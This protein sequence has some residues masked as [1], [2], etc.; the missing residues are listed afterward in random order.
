MVVGY[1]IYVAI[2]IGVC[3]LFQEQFVVRMRK[4]LLRCFPHTKTSAAA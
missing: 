3:L 4:L 2:T 1:L